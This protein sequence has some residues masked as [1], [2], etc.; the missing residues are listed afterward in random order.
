M[1]ERWPRPPRGPAARAH[2]RRMH[3]ACVALWPRPGRLEA[4]LLET[5]NTRSSI[6]RERCANPTP[7]LTLSRLHARFCWRGRLDFW[8][9]SAGKFA[10]QHRRGD[11]SRPGAP[12]HSN[13]SRYGYVAGSGALPAFV[14]SDTRVE[15]SQVVDQ[16][17]PGAQVARVHR[18]RRE[19]ARWARIQPAH[20]RFAAPL[21]ALFAPAWPTPKRVLGRCQWIYQA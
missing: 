3:P 15:C 2:S 8:R 5:A 7:A 20:S 14:S 4:A 13:S 17:Q 1:S 11:P 9:T 19:R 21:A 16:S 12:T 6:A 10:Q 18:E